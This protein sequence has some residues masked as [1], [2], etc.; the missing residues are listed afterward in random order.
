[1]PGM[2]QLIFFTES[3]PY[4]KGES[5]IENEIEYLSREFDRIYI[6]PKT[7]STQEQR[8]LPANCIVFPPIFRSSGELVFKG[9]F[10]FSPLFYFFKKLISEK[11]YTSLY[12]F[13][14]YI[15]TAITCRCILADKNFKRLNRQSTESTVYFYWGIG[16]AYIL[17]F[18]HNKDKK[19]VR[20][21]RTDLYADLRP[22]Q[23]IPFRKEVFESL[24]KAVFISK[25]GLEYA[26]KNFGQY[27]FS[28]YCSYLGTK[29]HGIS[30]IK[31]EDGVIH[32]LS[33]SNVVPVKRV[34]LILKSL[35]LI[36]DRP[37]QWTHIG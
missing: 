2:K 27:K 31:N 35:L 37:I 1:M 30:K 15:A 23:Y 19:I 6:L 29:D 16:M 3:F 4:G 34:S 21:H 26:K 5:F 10:C 12:K 22:H 7:S 36:P 13:K 32:I 9:L 33:C 17:P 18:I 8:S 14:K 11:A 28:A 25:Q 20:F 24:N